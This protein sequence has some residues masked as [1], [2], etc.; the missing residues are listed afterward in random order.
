MRVFADTSGLFAAVVR[1]DGEHPRARLVMERL[2]QQGAEIH[3]TSYV[4]LETLALLHS[5]VGRE[6]AAEFDRILRPLL[7]VRWVDE[8]LHA[9]ASRRFESHSDAKVSLVDC[10]SFTAMEDEGLGACFGFDGHFTREGF[11][12]LSAGEDL[13]A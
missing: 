3:T 2:L 10:A 6:A 8:A 7:R 5:R 9:R 13:T 11:R 1:N 12:L 4:L